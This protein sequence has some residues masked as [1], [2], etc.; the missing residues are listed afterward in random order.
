MQ[1]LVIE[2]AEINDSASIAAF[3]Q[4]MAWET[5]RYE[6]PP[7]VATQ[8]VLAVMQDPSKG[9]YVVAK[10]NNTVIASLLITYEWSDWRANTIWWIQSVYV[11]PELRNQHIFKN[12]YLHIKQLAQ[13]NSISVIRL[14]VEPN[15]QTAIQTYQKLNMTIQTYWV[16]ETQL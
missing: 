1:Q 11:K 10:I 8:G 3:N 7:A 9:F 14:Y 12:M 5:E 6:I 4:A 13:K 15:N 16:C 2:T